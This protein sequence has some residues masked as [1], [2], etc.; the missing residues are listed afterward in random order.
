MIGKQAS[1][2]TPPIVIA[3]GSI[4]IVPPA[5]IKSLKI[6]QTFPPPVQAEYLI[7]PIYMALLLLQG[8]IE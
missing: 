6:T 2:P 1:F 8:P 4:C 5:R 7:R 3:E